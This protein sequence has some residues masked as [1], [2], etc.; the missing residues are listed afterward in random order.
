MLK[1]KTE[2][3]VLFKSI[4][5]LIYTIVIQFSLLYY[6]LDPTNTLLK[7]IG[8]TPLTFTHLILVTILIRFFADSYLKKDKEDVDFISITAWFGMQFLALS[9]VRFCL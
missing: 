1:V 3:N 8:C 4:L 7:S 2:S 6:S 5:L 9:I